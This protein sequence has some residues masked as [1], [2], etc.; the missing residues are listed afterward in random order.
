MG[1]MGACRACE[2]HNMK[3]QD[4]KDLGSAILVSIPTTKNN[5]PRRFTI[6]ESY[7]NTVKKY[8]TLRVP[9]TP[10]TAFF[11]NYVK[12][13]CTKQPVGINK[14]A[15]FG[16]Q[17]AI[18]LKLQNPEC[19]TGHCFRRTSA[20]ILVDAG[21]DITALKRHGGWS[22]TAAA[23][24]YIN[25]SVQNKFNT[26]KKIYDTIQQPSKQTIIQENILMEMESNSIE[27]TISLEQK[28]IKNSLQNAPK[29]NFSNCNITINFNQTK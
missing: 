4:L 25:D 23:E 17:I 6:T 19:F 28:T 20:T 12:M 21:A 2:L 27:N 22:S 24:G 3:V 10:T 9:A 5:I 15:S 18:F 7:Y 11:V 14:L 8:T 26:A 1:I 13:K 16:K 29:L